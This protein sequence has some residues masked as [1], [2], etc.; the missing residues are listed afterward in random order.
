[1]E[2]HVADGWGKVADVFRANFHGNPG[3]VGPAC[4]V[5]VGG[6]PVVD[7]WGGLADCEANRPWH[8]DTIVLVASTT[9]GATAIC[10]HLLAQRGELDL[11]APVVTYWPE[12]GAAGKE[13]DHRELTGAV[14][15]LSVARNNIFDPLLADEALDHRHVELA[16]PGLLARSDL[17]D[18][19][20]FDAEKEGQLSQP[21]VENRFAAVDAF[22][23]CQIGRNL[24]QLRRGVERI[25]VRDARGLM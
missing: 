13:H 17:A 16:I 1:M 23:A 5:Y 4:C 10:A 2:G 9:K 24:I 18:L 12:F 19:V 7:L 14:D 6:R 11:D 3:E 20:R 25:G 15:H 21:L 8:H 22:R